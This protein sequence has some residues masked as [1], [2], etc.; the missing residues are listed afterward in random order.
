VTLSSEAASANAIRREQMVAQLALTL[1]QMAVTRILVEVD[2]TALVTSQD[3]QGGVLVSAYDGMGAYADFDAPH[4]YALVGGRVVT[5]DPQ[6]GRT[7][8]AAGPAG[9][10]EVPGRSLAVSLDGRRVATVSADGRSLQLV[11]FNPSAPVTVPWAGSDVSRPSWD[12]YGNIWFADRGPNGSQLRVAAGTGDG[13]P[14]DVSAAQLAGLTVL[15]VRVAPDAARI[16]LVVEGPELTPALMVG[17]VRWNNG[18]PSVGGLTSV[19][20]QI[21]DV[22]DV[23]CSGPTDLAVVGTVEGRF[24]EVAVVS[25]DGSRVTESVQSGITYVAAFSDEPLLAITG[26]ETLILQV[27]TTNWSTVTAAEAVTYPG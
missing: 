21:T 12:R 9:Q 22:R 14:V 17:W 13:E 24:A 20:P 3:P 7:A 27:T 6:T 25:V 8:T 11:S 2:G 1:R 19:A 16:A 4:G 18:V 26:D 10:G 15:S 23:A 5:I